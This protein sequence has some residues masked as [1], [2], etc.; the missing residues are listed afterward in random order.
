MESALALLLYVVAFWYVESPVL[1]RYC[2]GGVY[3]GGFIFAEHFQFTNF[4]LARVPKKRGRANGSYSL[5]FETGSRQ[6]ACTCLM[7]CQRK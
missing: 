7:S 5:S 1:Y 6:L 2:V 4:K 3:L